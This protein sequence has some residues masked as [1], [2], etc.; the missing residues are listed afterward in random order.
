MR[1][2][3]GLIWCYLLFVTGSCCGCVCGSGCHVCSLGACCLWH[4]PCIQCILRHSIGFVWMCEVLPSLCLRHL[5]WCCVCVHCA[6]SYLVLPSFCH[7]QLMWL[8]VAVG[9]M[10]ALWVPAAC[11]ICLVFN[12]FCNTPCALCGSVRCYLLF[13]LGSWCGVVCVHFVLY[14]LVLHSFCRRQ[15]MWLCVAVGVKASC[16]LS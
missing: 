9:V 14:A 1:I 12:A 13:V 7:R 11:G 10:C 3:L 16:S 2:V 6:W 15:L 4:L 8:C 5:V